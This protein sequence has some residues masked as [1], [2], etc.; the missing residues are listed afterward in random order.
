MYLRETKDAGGL[1]AG[2]IAGPG[3]PANNS[4][5]FNLFQDTFGAQHHG[6][7]NM[8]GIPESKASGGRLDTAYL[9]TEVAALAAV[10]LPLIG[11]LLDGIW[12]PGV[13]SAKRRDVAPPAK[14]W[15]AAFAPIT[16]IEAT[17][18]ISRQ[19]RRTTK[20]R[21]FATAF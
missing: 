7:V 18:I 11:G 15:V 20:A 8:P 4:I 1:S 16:S 5:Q 14:D 10:L 21:G 17:S 6:R 9:V 2:K 13:I 3:L 19:R 12:V